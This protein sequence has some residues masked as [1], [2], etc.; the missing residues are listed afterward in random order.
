MRLKPPLLQGS[1][2][3]KLWNSHVPC[4]A[5][6]NFQLRR[7]LPSLSIACP[8]VIPRLSEGRL[9]RK[10][11]HTPSILFHSLC[12]EPLPDFLLRWQYLGEL[13]AK[14]L[15]EDS[16]IVKII[17]S[18]GGGRVALGRKSPKPPKVLINE[19]KWWFSERLT[20]KYSKR[21]VVKQTDPIWTLRGV[22][23]LHA[24][25]SL[26][27]RSGIFSRSTLRSGLYSIGHS[28]WHLVLS[29]IFI[30]W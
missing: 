5:P 2:L 10:A 8:Y 11:L 3:T 26:C 29:F 9:L 7:L 25:M 13:L 6:R 21:I 15:T 19:V 12:S 18:W 23:R 4:S 1:S 14:R 28:W 22:K 17:S 24:M 27:G 30:P 20:K 16:W